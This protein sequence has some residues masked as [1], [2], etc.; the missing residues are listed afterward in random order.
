MIFQF[1]AEYMIKKC[2]Q[3]R[4]RKTVYHII[5]KGDRS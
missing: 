1:G 2:T 4:E 3:N 5:F